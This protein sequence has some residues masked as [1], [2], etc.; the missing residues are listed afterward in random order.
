MCTKL[1]ALPP[2]LFGPLGTCEHCMRRESKTSYTPPSS[3]LTIKFC[4]LLKI[5]LKH[6]HFLSLS[7]TP[8]SP[9]VIPCKHLPHDKH[10]TSQLVVCGCWGVTWC[11][12]GQQELQHRH[13][14]RI[15]ASR[16]LPHIQ[17]L[18]VV[19]RCYSNTESIV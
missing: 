9:L 17:E 14:D 18:P 16:A 19:T 10:D 5:F 6:T 15:N 12:H 7:D 13:G 4:S 8:I 2:P 11:S 1:N 3:F